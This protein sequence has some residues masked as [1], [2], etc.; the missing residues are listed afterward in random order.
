MKKSEQ[1]LQNENIGVLGLYAMSMTQ[2]F[3][4][5]FDKTYENSS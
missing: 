4:K 5:V 3:M 2:A 1:S